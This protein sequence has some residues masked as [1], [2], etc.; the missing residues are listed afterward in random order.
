MGQVIA[1]AFALIA[2][3]SILTVVFLGWRWLADDRADSYAAGYDQ[4]IED[5]R[6]IGLDA[7]ANEVR[8]Y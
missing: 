2:T 8:W 7:N 1:L 5:I 3:G 4:A 6:G